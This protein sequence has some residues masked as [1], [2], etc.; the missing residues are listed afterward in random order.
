MWAWSWILLTKVVARLLPFHCTCEAGKK[1]DPLNVSVKG[2]P[3]AGAL[4]G[5]MLVMVAVGFGV[6]VGVGVGVELG[7]AAEPEPQ[8]AMPALMAINTISK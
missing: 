4:L 6:G 1:L 7:R 5:A 2:K 8:P 3:P